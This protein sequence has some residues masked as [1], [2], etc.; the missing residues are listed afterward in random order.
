MTTYAQKIPKGC[1]P[2][3][4]ADFKHL[5][6]TLGYGH[7]AKHGVMT[8]DIVVWSDQP[9]QVPSDATH[10]VWFQKHTGNDK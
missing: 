5:P 4:V 9:S 8:T 10:I 1:E 6:H 7:P 2:I 3:P